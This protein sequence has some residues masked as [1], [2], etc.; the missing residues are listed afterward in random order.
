MFMKKRDIL[1][2][3]VCSAFIFTLL[4]LYIIARG[5]ELESAKVQSEAA[6]LEIDAS[7][8]DTTLNVSWDVSWPDMVDSIDY[9]SE[10][11]FY[12][13]YAGNI[14][15]LYNVKLKVEPSGI[16]FSF[17]E[18]GICSKQYN[19]RIYYTLKYTEDGYVYEAVSVNLDLLSDFL[20]LDNKL[21]DLLSGLT[22]KSNTSFDDT[23]KTLQE[24]NYKGGRYC[25]RETRTLNS[26]VRSDVFTQLAQAIASGGMF[27]DVSGFEDITNIEKSYLNLLV[28]KIKN[29]T[30]D[31]DISVDIM[32]KAGV[33]ETDR[34]ENRSFRVYNMRFRENLNDNTY[35]TLN[36]DG[37][38]KYHVYRDF[39]YMIATH[40]NTNSLKTQQVADLMGLQFNELVNLLDNK[41]DCAKSDEDRL[42]YYSY[43]EG[44]NDKGYTGV[45]KVKWKTGKLGVRRKDEV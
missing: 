7:D 34:L 26:N 23:G 35:I 10:E 40:G 6:D 28:D 41:E 31:L 18:E 43:Y 38:D 1:I 25:L 39:Y 13:T 29:K 19:D 16:T 30:A 5:E 42:N 14:S 2:V 12:S 4:C 15:L 9:L 37:Y 33:E 36:L 22:Y 11:D 21:E 3:S 27:Y 17:P 8:L 20:H 45:I 32:P 44:E 24:M